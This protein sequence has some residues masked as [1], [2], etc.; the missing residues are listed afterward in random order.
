MVYLFK[1]K[2][3]ER[4]NLRLKCE[5]KACIWTRIEEQC[6]IRIRFETIAL[7][8]PETLE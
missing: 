4:R 2:K 3:R 1:R 7:G 6:W 8:G 5:E